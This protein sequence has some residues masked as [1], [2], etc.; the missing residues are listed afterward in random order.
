[1]IRGLS[2]SSAL[3]IELAQGGVP[4][5]MCLLFRSGSLTGVPGVLAVVFM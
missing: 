1:M 5:A 2:G 4:V 3:Y